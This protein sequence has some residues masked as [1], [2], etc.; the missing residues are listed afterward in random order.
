ML[1]EIAAAYGTPEFQQVFN[2]VYPHCENIS[3]DYAIL[4]PRSA[5]GEHKSNLYCL[6]AEFGWNDLGS[7]ESLYEYHLDVRSRGDEDSNVA[8]CADHLSLESKGNYIYSP[9]KFVALIGVEDLVVVET[10]DAILIADR[11]HSQDVGKLVKELASSGR[12]EL[13]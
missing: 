7:W 12:K 10:E 2:D 9:K 5:K 11:R 4:E 3:V 13:I 6:P 8:E 1:E